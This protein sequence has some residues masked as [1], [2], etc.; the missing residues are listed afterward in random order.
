MTVELFE[1]AYG[2]GSRGYEPARSVWRVYFQ[3]VQRGPAAMERAPNA[4]LLASSYFS[5]LA[6]HQDAKRMAGESRPGG[7]VR[8][9]VCPPGVEPAYDWS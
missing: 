9:L 7:A 2:D 3:L 6:A 8:T 5:E 4:W 1:F